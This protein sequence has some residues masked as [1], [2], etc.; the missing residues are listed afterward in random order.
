MARTQEEKDANDMI[1]A[2]LLAYRDAYAAAHPDARVG[3]LTDWIVVAAEIVPGEDPEDDETAYSVIM[4]GG[5][6][7]GYKAAGLL[8]FG[9]AYVMGST[10]ED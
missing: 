7:P 3:T 4:P 5:G 2:S 9:K 1:E 8:D 6:I 10:S